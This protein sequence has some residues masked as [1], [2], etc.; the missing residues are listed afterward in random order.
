MPSASIPTDP[1]SPHFEAVLGAGGEIVRVDVNAAL[2]VLE[3]VVE[4]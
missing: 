1:S 3:E 2:P 4:R